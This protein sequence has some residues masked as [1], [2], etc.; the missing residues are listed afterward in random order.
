MDEKI[1]IISGL[2][3]KVFSVI[4]RFKKRKIDA[5][6]S[7]DR[8]RLID[9]EE[10]ESEKKETEITSIGVLKQLIELRN[11][12]NNLENNV[13]TNI[14]ISDLEKLNKR[15]DE[16]KD[17]ISNL[18]KIITK[19]LDKQE[20]RLESLTLKKGKVVSKTA[21]LIPSEIS[22]EIVKI[23]LKESE[24]E[25]YENNIKK[26]LKIANELKSIEDAPKNIEL[27]LS[28]L[29][30]Y[31]T[32]IPEKGVLES[33][34]LTKMIAKLF[35][36]GEVEPLRSPPHIKE[37]LTSNDFI[38][39]VVREASKSKELLDEIRAN[40]RKE[41]EPVKVVLLYQK[42]IDLLKNKA[43]KKAKEC[44]KEIT[45]MN[46]ELKGAWLN[47]GN[48][49]G[50]LGDIDE[51]IACYREAL[52]IDKRYKKAKHNKKIAEKKRKKHIKRSIK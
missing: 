9:R 52:R 20:D 3:N 31:G 6:A 1:S 32:D 13:L 7:E 2:K 44:F 47:R 16:Q 37:D 38:N 35:A 49:S 45:I 30:K 4:S 40:L 46:S 50:E 25:E 36:E 28:I 51:E 21:S 22:P 41:L 10:I 43:Y 27:M 33:V 34:G 15:V 8:E 48:A 23:S 11:K 14:Y 5:G 19:R 17:S 24:R 26:W 42:G 12:M 39:R 18:E 29:K